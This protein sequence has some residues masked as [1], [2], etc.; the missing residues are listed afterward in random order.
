MSSTDEQVWEKSSVG[1]G[2]TRRNEDN[3]RENLEKCHS[4]SPASP[5]CQGEAALSEHCLDFLEAQKQAELTD[6]LDKLGILQTSATSVSSVDIHQGDGAE[7][8]VFPSLTSASRE[9]GGFHQNEAKGGNQADTAEEKPWCRTNNSTTPSALRTRSTEE[10][11]DEPVS[12]VFAGEQDES[13]VSA[14]LPTSGSLLPE[15]NM[16]MPSNEEILQGDN[17]HRPGRVCDLS[18]PVIDAQERE[19]V[20]AGFF[21]RIKAV[22]YGLVEGSAVSTKPLSSSVLHREEADSSEWA[23]GKGME[24]AFVKE[25]RG[26]LSHAVGDEEQSSELPHKIVNSRDGTRLAPRRWGRENVKL[27]ISPAEPGVS[28]P[29]TYFEHRGRTRKIRQNVLA[30]SLFF[31]YGMSFSQLRIESCENA[32]S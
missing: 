14:V 7:F 29:A 16:Q 31:P 6:L 24:G 13:R 3:R 12:P 11:S 10:I 26:A 19:V 17:G 21:S 20:S 25:Y 32:F 4:T 28:F 23:R 15:E 2:V 5:P 30:D 9:V 22:V 1:G 18:R 8:E 27:K